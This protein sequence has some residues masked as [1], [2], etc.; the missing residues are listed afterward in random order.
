MRDRLRRDSRHS[1]FG[2]CG[3]P[4]GLRL[5]RSL[6]RPF[7]RAWFSL[8]WPSIDGTLRP[9]SCAAR[10]GYDCVVVFRARTHGLG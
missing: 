6:P 1:A 10:W 3:A 5:R 7:Q 8:F 9:Q 4:L 2:S